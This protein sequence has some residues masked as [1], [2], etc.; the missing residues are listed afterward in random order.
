MQIPLLGEVTAMRAFFLFLFFYSN[1]SNSLG[2]WSTFGA[3]MLLSNLG[4]C[5]ATATPSLCSRCAFANAR[6]AGLWTREA[7]VCLCFGVL[8]LSSS[9]KGLLV[10]IIISLYSIVLLEAGSVHPQHATNI[11][12]DSDAVTDSHRAQGRPDYHKSGT[13]IHHYCRCYWLLRHLP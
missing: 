9:R 7:P 1:D 3:G 6:A 4:N 5:F 13:I 2:T 12:S 11:W 8:Q 10:L